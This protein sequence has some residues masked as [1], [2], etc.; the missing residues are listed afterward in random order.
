MIEETLDICSE[1]ANLLCIKALDVNLDKGYSLY[2][3]RRIQP[4]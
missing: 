1:V 4:I 2:D 3:H